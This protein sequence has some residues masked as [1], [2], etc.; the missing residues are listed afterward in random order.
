MAKSV[1]YEGDVLETS[2]QGKY[3]LILI[4]TATGPYTY[5]CTVQIQRKVGSGSLTWNV[6]Y[7][8]ELYL[9]YRGTGDTTMVEHPL[10]LAG[11]NVNVPNTMNGAVTI[12]TYNIT[13]NSACT[14]DQR[15]IA[16]HYYAHNINGSDTYN[17]WAPSKTSPGALPVISNTWVYANGKWNQATQVWVYNGG[18]KPSTNGGLNVYNSGWKS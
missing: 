8:H 18:W 7:S 4:V 6:T 5:T 16:A 10:N 11:H 9:Y 12:G 2:L 15:K 1:T 14:A 13:V 17:Y 3:K